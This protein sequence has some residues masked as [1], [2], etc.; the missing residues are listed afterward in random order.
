M[1]LC[2]SL[3]DLFKFVHF[4]NF[5]TYFLLLLAKSEKQQR[6]IEFK[7]SAIQNETL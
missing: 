6:A 3:V 5:S 7:A 4:M 2:L 1:S